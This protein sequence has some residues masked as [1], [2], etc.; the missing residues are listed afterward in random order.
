[1][2]RSMV[3][4]ALFVP[5]IF[6]FGYAGTG[7]NFVRT[8]NVIVEVVPTEDETISSSHVSQGDKE[9]VISGRVHRQGYAPLEKGHVDIEIINPDGTLIK[10]CAH[11][12]KLR[13]RKLD[14]TV[15]FAA[16]FPPLKLRKGTRISLTY[17]HYTSPE[18]ILFPCGD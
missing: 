8:G 1:M 6:L 18:E 3:K 4:I 11:Y 13:A 15:P 10:Q 2:I 17:H 7:V 16:H 5:L 12:F 14:L 9:L